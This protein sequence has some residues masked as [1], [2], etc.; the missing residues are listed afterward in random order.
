M[1]STR[2][3]AATAALAAGALVLTSCGSPYESEVVEGTTITVAYNNGFFHFNSGSSAGNNTSNGNVKYITDAGF[4]Y[5]DSKPELI[6][7]ELF[8]TFE[9]TSSDPLV[10]K[11]T[12]N[13]GPVW[14]DSVPI[15]EADLLLSWATSAI[16]ADGKQL[17]PMFTVPAGAAVA[18]TAAI[19]EREIT[20][21][22]AEPY[23]D[24]ELGYGLGVSAHG[25]YALA[26][27]DEY[28]PV[29]A[30]YDAAVAAGDGE[31]DAYY[32]A[33][34]EFAVGAK[35]KVID[36]IQGNDTAFLTTF[37]GVWA[38]GYGYTTLPASPAAAL[39]SGPYVID[40][41]VEDSHITLKANPLFTGWS[42]NNKFEK[43][44]IRTIT[45]PSDALQALQN[46]EIDIWSGQPTADSLM[47][48]QGMDGVD[49]EQRT[50]AS[51]EHIDLTMNNGGPF[52]AAA[53]GG[54]EAKAQKVRVAFL[55][56]IPRDEIVEKLIK[57]L[58]AEAEVRNSFRVIPGAPAYDNIVANNGLVESFGTLDIEG[59]KA[60][61]AE[62]GVT[63]PVDVK[64][65]FPTGNVRR[66]S[67]FELIAQSAAQAG[68]NVIANDEP[69]WLF[70]D[71]E[72]ELINP[73]D[74]TIFAW[75]STSLAVSG[76][77]Q[78][79]GC[80][81]DPINKGGNYSGYCNP[82]VDALIAQLNTQPDP[83]QQAELILEIEKKLVEDAYGTVIFQ[84][85]G[86]LVWNKERVTG[87]VDN[88]L[89][90]NYFWNFWDW[91]PVLPEAPAE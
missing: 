42:P 38:S 41:I 45:N 67:E 23:P 79:F 56:T 36:A 65:W 47:I 3:V 8:G 14:S 49:I 28:A 24:W 90:P 35:Q 63:T 70:T 81:T 89:S 50:Q 86:L 34:R 74:A 32:E 5:Y 75:S 73:H 72:V 53:Y 40:E 44:T 61:L 10:V 9:M 51:Y 33:A 22:Y 11:Y 13:E 48:A 25:T 18:T 1:K 15:D 39:T 55:K 84:F 69:D 27:P 58:D 6:R 16:G 29:Q 54:D 19:A 64:F 62:V 21:T 71:P 91:T 37:G 2:I 83:A 52:D 77:D 43:I 46:G 82:A 30:A 85:P 12:V 57:P 76:D 20:L 7:N 66:Q 60:L 80:Y 88:P 31:F 17:Y 68:F 87:V 59:A 4:A 26:F 78:L